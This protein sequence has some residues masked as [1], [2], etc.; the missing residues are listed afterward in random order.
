MAH[1]GYLY[2]L[3]LLF[4]LTFSLAYAIVNANGN[5]RSVGFSAHDIEVTYREKID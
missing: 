1:A 4:L 2:N 5:N 3:F